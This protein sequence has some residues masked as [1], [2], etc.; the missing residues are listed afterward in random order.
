MAGPVVA[1]AIIFNKSFYHP[2]VKDSKKLSQR[3]RE[4][5]SQIL[6]AN[7]VA[8]HLGEA[9][10]GEIERHNIRQATFLAMRRAISGLSITPEFLLIDGEDLPDV[11]IPS[12]GIIHGDDKSFTISA[13]SIVAKVARDNYMKE[14]DSEYPQYRFAKNKGYGTREHIEAIRQIGPTPHHRPSFLTKILDF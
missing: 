7:A 11:E 4:H 8:F 14:L 13:A 2:D 5:L 1:C 10:V 6:C 9:S 12:K 3:K